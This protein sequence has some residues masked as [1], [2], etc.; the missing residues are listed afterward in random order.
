MNELSVTV[1]HN[2]DNAKQANAYIG[3]VQSIVNESHQELGAL[4][5]L[6]TIFRYPQARLQKL[7]PSLTV[8]LFKPIFLRSMLRWKPRVPVSRVKGSP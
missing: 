4:K 1:S 5:G 7:H 2:M 8:S 3:Q 6:L